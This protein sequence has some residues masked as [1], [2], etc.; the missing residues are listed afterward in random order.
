MGRLTKHRSIRT[1]FGKRGAVL[2][3]LLLLAVGV[4]QAS[5]ANLEAPR[6]VATLEQA[7]AA[8]RGIGG[9]RRPWLAATLYC[10]A[11]MM[12]S[13]EGFYQIGRL[14][15]ERNSI[16]YNP[17]LAN[18]Y[19][20][21]AVRLGHRAALDKHVPV[22]DEAPLPDDCA[23]FS[24]RLA[25]EA[26]DVDGYLAVLPLVRQRIATLIRRHAPRFDVDARFALA[27]ALAE[28][29]LNQHAVSPKNAQGVMQLI[30]ETQERFGVRR[31]FDPESNIRG[32]LIYIRWLS[33]RFDGDLALVAAA[34]NAGEGMVEKYGGIP[35]FPE[36]QQY[37][38]RVF[39]FSGFPFAERN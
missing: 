7:A 25:D 23:E 14:L 10:D 36:T 6:V 29:N 17:A 8:E 9:F 27:V 39:Y 12:G 31:P 4:A 34:Y 32:A 11:G 5:D 24:R 2:L 22:Q 28:S 1:S 18:A 21:L 30:P 26:F 38:R 3:S 37:V 33:E 19:L 16:V 15:N 13:A 20:G 35:P